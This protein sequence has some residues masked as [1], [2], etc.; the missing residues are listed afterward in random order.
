MPTRKSKTTSKALTKTITVSA[1]LLILQIGLCFST[2]YTW[3]WFYPN[4]N[5]ED[6]LQLMILQS[7]LCLCTFAVLISAC[8][9]WLIRPKSTPSI[10]ETDYDR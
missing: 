4:S 5:S 6:G 3:S 9:H 8:I 2:P 10:E 7:F 1:T